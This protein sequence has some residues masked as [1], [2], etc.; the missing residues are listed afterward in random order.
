M[1]QLKGVLVPETM[2]GFLV[3]ATTAGPDDRYLDKVV[4]DALSDIDVY[5]KQVKFVL[6]M[7]MLTVF[8]LSANG[9]LMSQKHAKRFVTQKEKHLI[10]LP[11]KDLL[12]EQ[13]WLFFVTT[14]D[15]KVRMIN[16]KVA[17]MLFERLRKK[18]SVTTLFLEFLDEKHLRI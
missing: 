4:E 11:L 13:V 14:K 3:M 8:N 6:Y 12:C 16:R 10:D 5:P 15:N 9:Y 2:L 7:A 1:N 17:K 18:K